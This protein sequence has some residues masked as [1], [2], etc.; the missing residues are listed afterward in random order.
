MT[1]PY[2]MISNFSKMLTC[3]ECQTVGDLN[4]T[5][6]RQMSR[7]EVGKCSHRKT[8]FK[9]SSTVKFHP[10]LSKVDVLL[11]FQ[12]RNIMN[13][14]HP[15]F[16]IMKWTPWA[17]ITQGI[18]VCFIYIWMYI[19]TRVHIYIYIH[20][21]ILA[22]LSLWDLPTASV[23]E[24]DVPDRS[25][26]FGTPTEL[27]SPPKK[28]DQIRK[29][30]LIIWTNHQFSENVFV[31]RGG[32]YTYTPQRSKKKCSIS[33]L[34]E[35]TFSARMPSPPKKALDFLFLSGKSSSNPTLAGP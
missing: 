10:K 31:F 6:T 2:E 23:W 1:K 19:Y 22:I 25:A 32:I 20:P 27:F 14:K 33:F 21:P 9:S 18:Y 7:V 11:H 3:S 16:S 15:I 8:L 29:G 5:T 13:I 30:K 35:F 17:P 4:S 24:Q 12:P 26:G 34:L 28:W